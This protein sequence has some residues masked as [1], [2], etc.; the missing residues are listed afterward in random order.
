MTIQE[1]IKSGKPFKNQ[2]IHNWLVADN[3]G[4]YLAFN[5]SINVTLCVQ[6]ILATD[7]E[8]KP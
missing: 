1:A 3:S 6:D 4:F 7:W 8:V 2:W 5:R